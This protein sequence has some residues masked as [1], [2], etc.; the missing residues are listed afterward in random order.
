MR[1]FRLR[2]PD[3]VLV[4]PLYGATVHD[5][6]GRLRVEV[7]ASPALRA[8]ERI[9]IVLDGKTVARTA[10]TTADLSGVVRGTHE[11]QARIVADH[12]A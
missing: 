11:L 6:S 8:G 12:H 3:I 7:E 5:N 1:M 2:V 4:L 10:S 9:A